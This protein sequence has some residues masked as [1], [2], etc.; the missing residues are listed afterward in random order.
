MAQEVIALSIVR[1]HCCFYLLMYVFSLC[2]VV[3]LGAGL[4]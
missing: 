1:G 3:G 4:A 2:S